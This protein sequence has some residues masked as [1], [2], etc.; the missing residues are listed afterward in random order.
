MS[1]EI[2]VQVESVSKIYKLYNSRRSFVK[3]ALS[4][5]RK[6]Y[7]KDFYALKDI[8]FKVNKGKMIGIIGQNGSGKSTL[9]KILASIVTPTSGKYFTKGT[10]RALIELQG[11]FDEE[12]TGIENIRFLGILQGYSKKEM[13]KRIPKILEFADIGEYAYQPVK[14]YSSGMNVRLAFSI[15]IHVDPEILIV[16]EALAVG[17]IRFQ[18]KCYRRINELKHEGKTIV[19]CTHGL[20]T[21]KEFCDRAIWL[22]DGRIKE[23]GDPAFVV[24]LYRAYMSS[25][26][27]ITN[28]EITQRSE[29]IIETLTKNKGFVGDLN[30]IEWFDISKCNSYGN[31]NFSIKTC[32]ILN[33]NTNKSI[34]VFHGGEAI[35]ILIYVTQHKKIDTL[36]ISILLNN[37]L[38]S[39]IFKI[40][41]H[42]YNQ[43]IKLE[44]G[45]PSVVA[46]DF[47]FP[48]LGNGQYTLSMGAIHYNE[49]GEQTDY[50]VHDAVIL[51]VDNAEFKYKLEAPLVLDEVK[52]NVTELTT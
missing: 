27:A 19:L 17:D 48:H 16:D 1:E 50:W 15:A 8:S 39:P 14:N 35:R 46:V 12:L 34:H 25:Q 6:K 30:N 24:D 49:D 40:N 18:Q 7:H 10:T 32:T 21:V 4:P 28:K 38:G 2:A 5:F 42:A 36:G 33:R 22:H 3:E 52:M 43:Y 11:G 13:E 37:R 26:E 47:Y 45:K 31:G 41:S 51:T 23:T 29:E 9:L 44:I 20:D